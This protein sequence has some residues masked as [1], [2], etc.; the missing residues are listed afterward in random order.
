MLLER[1]SRPVRGVR[2][3]RR[4]ALEHGQTACVQ[5]IPMRQ[6]DRRDVER[7]LQHLDPNNE[8]VVTSALSKRE[9]E[10]FID[11]GFV[12]R[13]SLHLLHHDLRSIQPVATAD[14]VVKLR[15]GRRTDLSSVLS[16]DHRSFDDFWAMDRDDLNAARKATPTHR[17]MVATLNNRVVGYAVTGRAGTSTFL[18]RLGVEPDLRRKGIGSILVRDALQWARETGGASMLVNTQ[19]RN[20]RALGLYEHLGFE[21]MAEQLKVLE[22][23]SQNSPSSAAAP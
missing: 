12:E 23:P 9:R 18:Q 19:D 5:I 16:I 13:E 21:L 15:T 2:I 7:L 22:W 3:V 1:L 17:Y 4:G 6:L 10:A 20:T 11:V 8:L 14:T